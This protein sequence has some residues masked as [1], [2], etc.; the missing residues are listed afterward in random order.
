[1]LDAAGRRDKLVTIQAATDTVDAGG[2]PVQIFAD[3]P[4]KSWM[5]KKDLS[6]G[7]RFAERFDANQVSARMYTEWQLMYRADM[8]PDAVNVQKLRR[9]SYRGRT[10]DIVHGS[11]MEAHEGRGIKLITIAKP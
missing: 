5:S 9:L 11:L 1:M 7:E 8:D 4:D 2:F 6:D 3:L 10:Y